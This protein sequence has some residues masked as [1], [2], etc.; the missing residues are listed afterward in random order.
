MQGGVPCDGRAGTVVSLDMRRRKQ[1]ESDEQMDFLMKVFCVVVIGGFIVGGGWKM[2]TEVKRLAS[3]PP[4]RRDP[5]EF[6]PR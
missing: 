3:Q 2:F 4:R 5:W 1:F 6:D